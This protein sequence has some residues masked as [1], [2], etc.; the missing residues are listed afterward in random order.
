MGCLN[1]TSPR[2]FPQAQRPTQRTALLLFLLSLLKLPLFGLKIHALLRLSE[3]TDADHSINLRP[4]QFPQENH[5]LRF[6]LD[7]SM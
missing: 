6:D 2:I 7:S 3:L 4:F 5:H 1:P